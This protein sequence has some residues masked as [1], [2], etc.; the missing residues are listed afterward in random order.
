MIILLDREG[1]NLSSNTNLDKPTILNRQRL[2]TPSH[3]ALSPTYLNLYCWVR[4]RHRHSQEP[5][6]SGCSNATANR[7]SVTG[8]SLRRFLCDRR[9]S[10]EGWKSFRLQRA[11][12]FFRRR[13]R[14]Q[15]MGSRAKYRSHG[16]A[17]AVR[18]TSGRRACRRRSVIMSA[19]CRLD[20]FAYVRLSNFFKPNFEYAADCA[21][22]CI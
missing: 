8:Y 7:R 3:L 5:L 9:L 13:N 10:C 20:H 2:A 22:L 16:P 19:S 21:R 17:V 12:I 4:A 6:S 1:L 14:V 15:T 18:T 11:R